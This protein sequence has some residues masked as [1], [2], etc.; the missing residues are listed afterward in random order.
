M[1]IYNVEK[2][3]RE[4]L[5]SIVNQTYTNLEIILVNDGSTDNCDAICDEYAL[6]DK[7]IKVIHKENGGLGSA[8]NTGLDLASGDY[9]GFVESDDFIELNMYEQL[10]NKIV[11]LDCDICIGMFFWHT[12]ENIRPNFDI[13][14]FVKKPIFN[15]RDYPQFLLMHSSIWVKLYKRKS[16]GQLRFVDFGGSGYYCDIPFWANALCEAKKMCKIDSCV[17]HYRIDNPNASSI[18]T[19]SDNKLLQIIPSLKET[20]SIFKKY[21]LYNLLQEEI[22]YGTILTAFRYFSNIDDQYKQDFFLK[23]RQFALDFNIN[24]RFH[25]SCFY[26]DSFI[27][28]LRK[29]FLQAVLKNDYQQAVILSRAIKINNAQGVIKSH[30]SW[31]IGEAILQ[32][33]KSAKGILRLPFIIAKIAASHQ[34][35]KIDFPLEGYNDYA[36][37]VEMKQTLTYKLGNTFVQSSSFWGMIC[38]PFQLV[39]IY[40]WYKRKINKIYTQ[41]EINKIILNELKFI[42]EKMN[43]NRADILAATMHKQIFSQYNFAFENKDIVI[44]GNGESAKLY[45]NHIKNAIHIGVNRCFHMKNIN[46]DYIFC[47]HA[48]YPEGD[49]E[50]IKYI[51]ENPNIQFFMGILPTTFL[52]NP[53]H[54]RHLRGIYRYK[55]VSPYIIR[56]QGDLWC[57]DLSHEPLADLYSVIFSALQFACYTQPKRIYLVGC[58]CNNTHISTSQASINASYEHLYSTIERK[59]TMVVKPILDKFYSDIEIIS[60]NP[61]GLKGLFKDVY[62]N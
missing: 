9:I 21:D 49:W 48:L 59:W 53:T 16:L 55:N 1:P 7:R 8:Y 11:Q 60:L 32:N 61:V 27:G 20:V 12:S 54:Y 52:S 2:Y 47:H 3:L 31:K 40:K 51:A 50:L 39:K 29:K 17:Y 30:L 62:T 26:K 28:E 34:K 5:D 36:K 41:D 45:T 10:C 43:E 24:E 35:I 18:G 42:T 56:K 25:F 6:K 13:C 58:D 19:R 15:I 4:C 33:Y 14:K 44:V 38:L 23:L 57:Y 22:V 46:F 37:A